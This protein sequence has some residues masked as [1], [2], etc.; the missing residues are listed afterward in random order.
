VERTSFIGCYAAYICPE[1]LNE[2][3]Q[4]V[5]AKRLGE[6]TV[7]WINRKWHWA[8]RNKLFWWD[9]V[10]MAASVAFIF[11]WKSPGESDFRVKTLGM[12]LQL[13]GVG[14]VWFDLTS[15]A[16]TFGKTGMIQRTKE[17]LKAGFTGDAT[18]LLSGVSAQA[19]AT[20]SARATV[21]WPIDPNAVNS[22]RIEAL[23]KNLW[24]IDEDINALFR[25]LDQHMA[26]AR[27]RASNEENMR[28]Q[29]VAE[30]RRE[31]IEASVGNFSILVFGAVWLAVGVVLST[32]APE[33]AKIAAG[34]WAGV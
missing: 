7:I 5:C 12:I 26:V 25:E 18:V 24:K 28:A 27:E 34:N 15:A 30:V 29:A 19:N 33:I 6:R 21:R 1:L 14:T 31:L 11:I 2:W 20:W 23:E 4:W 10:L 3:A 22:A 13:I 17:W 32:W 16:R 8:M 9:I